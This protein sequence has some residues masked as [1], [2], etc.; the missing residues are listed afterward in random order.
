MAAGWFK[1]EDLT[2]DLTATGDVFSV[3]FANQFGGTSTFAGEHAFI[4]LRGE[5]PDGKGVESLI[6]H[7]DLG[8]HDAQ[9]FLKTTHAISA[10]GTDWLSTKTLTASSVL[11]AGDTDSLYNDAAILIEIDGTDYWFPLYLD[12]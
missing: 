8:T 12:N 5:S 9:S 1:V 3:V 10:T 2:N 11:G 4:C 6:F 7:N